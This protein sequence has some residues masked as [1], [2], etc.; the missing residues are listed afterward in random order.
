MI[1]GVPVIVV[2]EEI[3]ITTAEQVHA[4]LPATALE[5]ALAQRPAAAN[6]PEARWTARS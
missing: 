5:Q 4:N 1:S 3:D 6:R 2:P